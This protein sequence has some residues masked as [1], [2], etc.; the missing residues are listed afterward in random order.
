MVP[1][2]ARVDAGGYHASG[3][4]GVGPG[5]VIPEKL[6]PS[7][8]GAS[9]GVPPVAPPPV[10]TGVV[11]LL[12]VLALSTCYAG[13][14]ASPIVRGALRTSYARFG[15][16]ELVIPV[17]PTLL[18]DAENLRQIVENE[19]CVAVIAFCD[20]APHG[21]TSRMIPY[22]CSTMQALVARTSYAPFAGPEV[23]C[24]VGR[25]T[26]YP[27][28]RAAVSLILPAQSLARTSKVCNP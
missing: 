20:R 13:A 19:F 14:L 11:A 4:G 5:G 28:W 24:V 18:E 9:T 3:A 22:E 16:R 8:G 21:I 10:P 23:I 15:V 26:S 27:K 6:G 17:L 7:E 12:D 25:V 2:T 1:W